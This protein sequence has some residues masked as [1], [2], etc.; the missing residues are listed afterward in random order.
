M[1]LM[2]TSDTHYGL[3]GANEGSHRRFWRKVGE[4]IENE[5][6]QVLIWAGDIAVHRQRQ[7]RRSIEIC[8][9][10]VK[11][12]IVLVRGNH[13]FWDH[14]DKKDRD[15]G[16]RSFRQL[17]ELHSKLF[18]EF[19][20]HH[21]EK[22]PYVSGDTV[23]L[24]WDGWYYLSNPPTKDEVH[25]FR[26]VEGCPM[27][28]FMANRAHK[29][30][31]KVLDFDTSTFLNI[32][33]VTHHNPYR[34]PSGRIPDSTE[35]GPNPKFLDLIAEKADVL[36]Y[37]HNHKKMDMMYKGCRLLNSGSDYGYPQYTIFTVGGES[38]L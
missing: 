29:M 31:E 13:D 5:G 28:V 3:T 20:I 7:L 17:E 27:H 34:D 35:F 38:E 15:A 24:G 14:P 4:A 8:R 30:F 16:R 33:A 37:G 26:D 12:P 21:L 19:D 23:I 22:G 11:I 25:M 6:V 9:E 2:L 32:V 1:K 10:F 18:A 36:C